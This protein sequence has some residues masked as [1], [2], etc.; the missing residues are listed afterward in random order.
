[1]KRSKALLLAAG[2]GAMT[3]TGFHGANAASKENTLVMT[4]KCGPVTIEMFKDKA[5]A[6]VA[7][8]KKLVRQ[9]FYNGIIFHRVI[10]GFM[11]Q[12]GDPTGTGMGGSRLPD[13][14][15]EFNSV[16]FDRGVVGM[17]RSSMPDSA[18]SQFFIMYAPKYH[19]N[20][21]YTAWGR[22]TKGMDCVD[23][24]NKGEPPAHPDKIIKMQV[25]ADIK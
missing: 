13:L 7:Q 19:L 9:G 3:L 6:H 8:I 22:V 11:A 4:L 1:M 18:N 17:A 25:L 5:P 12:T 15:A 10:A 21:Q 24:I 23:K 20:G 16:P 14:K 2:I